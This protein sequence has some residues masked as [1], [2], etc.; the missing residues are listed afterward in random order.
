[1]RRRTPLTAAVLAVL[2]TATACSADPGDGTAPSGRP[3]ASKA[4]PSKAA[5]SWEFEHIADFRGEITDLAAL[6]E[7][8]IW[9]VTKSRTSEPGLLHYDGERWKSEPLPQA[10]ART[11]YPPRLE[12]IDDSTLWLRPEPLEADT[13]ATPWLS[14]DGKRWTPVPDPPSGLVG[15]LEATGPDDIWTVAGEQTVRHWDGSRWIDSR[16]PH[17]V[18]DLAIAGPDDVW[19]AGYR[20]QGPGTDLGQGQTYSQPATSH[21]DG[22]AWKSV[23]TPQYRF[24]DPVPPEPGAGLRTL[25]VREDGEVRAYGTHTFN[26]GETE[27]EPADEAVRLRWD[28]TEWTRMPG[29][30]GGC[31]DRPPVFDDGKGLLLEGNW[32]VTDSGTCRKIERHRLPVST[33]ARKASNQSL[34]LT[35]YQRVPGTDE[36]IGAG[37]VQVNQSGDPFGAPVIVRLKRG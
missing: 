16:L 20:T 4:G 36:I 26:H 2:L 25:F 10:S 13:T 8:D 15:T 33:G 11:Q 7:N 27:P 6:A 21:W 32:Y 23:D 37:H 34:W 1:M 24:P 29:E 28:G 5:L 31:G 22:S 17:T 12:K 30:K 19:A 35:S 14:W 3:G 18:T 9:A